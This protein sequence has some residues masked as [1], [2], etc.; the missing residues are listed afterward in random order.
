MIFKST[1]DRDAI[2]VVF[3]RFLNR[4]PHEFRHRHL[5]LEGEAAQIFVALVF[6]AHQ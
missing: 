6:H 1:L 4:V 2:E 5:L 3:E